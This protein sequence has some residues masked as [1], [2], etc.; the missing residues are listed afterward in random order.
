MPVILEENT[1]FTNVYVTDQSSAGIHKLLENI[2]TVRTE[3]GEQAFYQP[4]YPFFLRGLTSF[5]AEQLHKHGVQVEWR[6]LPRVL[7][8]YEPA[9][10]DFGRHLQPWVV[11]QMLQHRYGILALATRFGKSY[12]YAQWWLRAGRPMTVIFVP[13]EAIARQ[14]RDEL[15]S[16]LNEPVGIIGASVQKIPDWQ[17][18]T[19]CIENSLFD[20]A[21]AL[22]PEHL[23]YLLACEAR[24]RDECHKIGNRMI[25]VYMAMENCIF[26]WGGSATPLTDNALHNWMMIGWHGPLRVQI[27]ANLAAQ[28]GIVAPAQIAWVRYNHPKVIEDR[29]FDKVYHAQIVA[30]N[31]RNELIA[32][33]ARELTSKGK[34]GLIFVNHAEHTQRLAFSIPNS[35]VVASSLV[36][37]REAEIIKQQFNAGE[38]S[39]VVTTKKWREGVTFKCDFAINAEAMKADHV[40]VQKLGRGLIPKDSG[41]PLLWID[42]SDFGYHTF[43]KQAQARSECYDNEGWPQSYYA[44]FAGFQQA[45]WSGQV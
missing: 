39:C 36:T 3:E 4:G 44:N 20:A 23:P 15:A 42:I 18:L 34:Q 12:I 2:L 6:A 28:Y 7:R 40:T 31:Q 25:A 24:I 13:T 11:E 32:A 16:V 21:G 26:S 17:R 37:P 38:V 22:R 35:M 30:N 45:L 29:S 41:K 1:N 19:V 43:V 14:M 5:V 9:P 8:S 10:A 27:P 33:I